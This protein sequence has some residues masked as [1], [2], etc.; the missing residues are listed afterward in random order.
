MLKSTTLD[1]SWMY[2]QHVL[3]ITVCIQKLQLLLKSSGSQQKSWHEHVRF[4]LINVLYPPEFFYE[5]NIAIKTS[6][7]D[8]RYFIAILTS[9]FTN[10]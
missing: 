9:E 8:L 2:Y 3:D 4:I 5:N 10:Y 7:H 1:L 6:L